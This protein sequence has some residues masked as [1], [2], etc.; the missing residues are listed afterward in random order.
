MARGKTIEIYLVDGVHSGIRVI[1]IPNWEG[2]V[3]TTSRNR[4]VEFL[5]RKELSRPS[6]YFLVGNDDG[7]DSHK[8]V[9]IGE[10]EEVR[11]RVNSHRKKDYWNQCIVVTS[12]K[13]GFTKDHVR[14]LESQ[15]CKEFEKF[16]HVTLENDVIPSGP[17]LPDRTT[18]FLEDFKDYA[19]LVLGTLELYLG[20][21]T[22]EHREEEN[23][24]VFRM[25]TRDGVDAKME[26][27]GD[28]YKVLTGSIIGQDRERY[29][30]GRYA[31]I[32]S[33]R[34]SLLEKD[35]LERLEDGKFKLKTDVYY[36]SPSGASSFCMGKTSNGRND[37]KIGKKT[38]ADIES[39]ELRKI[40]D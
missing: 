24:V 20:D 30:E 26:I 16:A 14:W 38:L 17:S 5:K 34:K 29:K 13:D 27:E 25:K 7:S 12:K 4:I 2:I 33:K 11:K 18:D 19:D 10:S 35:L 37:W 40:S 15:F 28:A 8:V 1:E 22:K 31:Y 9:Y 36:A 6:L 3:L 23:A 32:Y 39:D 21:A